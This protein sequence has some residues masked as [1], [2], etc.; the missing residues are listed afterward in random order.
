MSVLHQSPLH[1]TSAGLEKALRQRTDALLARR[2]TPALV[3]ESCLTAWVT[4]WRA[5]FARVIAMRRGIG[6]A[7]A[8]SFCAC[9]CLT[10]AEVAQSAR[11]RGR[12]RYRY[13]CL[14]CAQM[15]WVAHLAR[16]LSQQAVHTI[17]W[18]V[19]AHCCSTV[20]RV[21]VP[22]LVL[23]HVGGERV[24]VAPPACVVRMRSSHS[25]ARATARVGWRVER[26]CAAVAARGWVRRAPRTARG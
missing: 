16:T 18:E 1:V 20:R 3:A 25:A 21:R 4:K 23:S 17:V 6:R 7:W 5:A 12:G 19:A 9:W 22:P 13:C 8:N 26:V 14:A 11:C 2:R 15:T 24:A 10:M